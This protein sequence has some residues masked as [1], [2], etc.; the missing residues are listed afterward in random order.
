M[1]TK[2]PYIIGISILIA[3]IGS[4]TFFA[5]QNNKNQSVA[6][7]QHSL[8]STCK[9]VVPKSNAKILPFMPQNLAMLKI[10]DSIIGSGKEVKTGDTICIH[11][12]GTLITGAEFDSSY[13]RNSPFTTQ[14]GVGNV[15]EGWDIG[16]VGLKE[17]GKRKIVIPP[18]LGYGEKSV[19]SIPA[20]STLIFDVELISIKS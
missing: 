12:R 5:F 11:Y 7:Y 6:V 13:K 16:I 1:A 3:I 9:F 4:I 19:G 10:E 17:G 20:N 2:L 15:I 8:A 18:Q 14:I